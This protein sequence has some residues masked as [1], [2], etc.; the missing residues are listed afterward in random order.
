MILY[1]IVIIAT[2]IKYI[3]IIEYC[4]IDILTGEMRQGSRCYLCSTSSINAPK[5]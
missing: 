1:L 4:I 3:L 2:T 5:V